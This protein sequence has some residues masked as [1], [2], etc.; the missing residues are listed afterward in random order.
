MAGD[1]HQRGEPRLARR[2][3]DLGSRDGRSAGLLDRAPRKARDD[4]SA[5]RRAARHATARRPEFRLPRAARPLR[6]RPRSRLAVRR[7]GRAHPGIPGV[8]H[9]DIEFARNHRRPLH[10]DPLQHGRAV[11][12]PGGSDGYHGTIQNPYNEMDEYQGRLCADQGRKPT[13]DEDAMA[14][15]S[16]GPQADIALN[17]PPIRRISV[18]EQT[19]ARADL[20]HRQIDDLNARAAKFTDCDFS[21]SIF[22][23]AYFRDAQFKNCQFTGCQF[24]DCNLKNIHFYTCD[25]RFIRFFR[26]Q[27]DADEIV[28]ALPFEP[29]IRREALQNLRANAASVGD[30]SSQRLLILQEIE[31]NKDHHRRALRGVDTYYRE[32][33]SSTISKI[34]A[35]WRLFWLR[36]SGLVW[37]HGERPGRILF[38]GATILLLLTL[39]NFWGVMPRVAWAQTL[40]GVH[41]LEYTLSLFFWRSG[42]SQLQRVCIGR[43]FNFNCEVRICWALYFCA[44]QKNI[45]PLENYRAGRSMGELTAVYIFGS[46]GRGQQDERSDLDLL[47]VVRDGFGKVADDEV[48]IHV[49]QNLRDLKAGIS[50]YGQKRLI[51]MYKNGELFA[52]HL[53]KETIPV[54]ERLPFLSSLGKPSFYEDAAEDVRSFHMVLRGIPEQLQNNE[55]NAIYETGLIYVCLRNIAMAAS[56]IFCEEP[57]FSRYSPF[58]LGRVRECPIRRN[59]Y[60]TTM[61]CR[62]A[63]QRGLPFPAGVDAELAMRIYDRID[64]WIDEIYLN[65]RERSIG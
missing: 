4:R 1:G 22:T 8:D 50:W 3:G 53:H 19:L 11:G 52:W 37:G 5:E 9:D 29:N 17:I 7:Q 35:G 57:D 21:Y 49:P 13:S 62:M 26:C 20:R 25:L 61:A 14:S 51:E 64:P 41:I 58:C 18:S 47:A 43:L 46:V 54:F 60:E 59:E 44:F 12:K 27:L 31:A 36:I 15:N 23:R 24:Y 39:I 45:T 48:L 38:S 65:L 2:R 33:Y 6:R 16:A 55:F 56:W 42:R 10:S 63:A 40:G 28:A 30:F 32:K 34:Q